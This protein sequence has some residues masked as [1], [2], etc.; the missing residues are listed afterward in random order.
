MSLTVADL[1]Y[2]LHRIPGKDAA[3]VGD[4]REGGRFDIEHVE[5]NE[6]GEVSLHLSDVRHDR[7]GADV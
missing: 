6:D 4:K 5:I 2:E 3:V 1:M 7:S